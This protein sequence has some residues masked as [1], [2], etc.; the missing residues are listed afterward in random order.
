L[1][2]RAD[3]SLWRQDVEFIASLYNVQLRRDQ[4]YAVEACM[5]KQSFSGAQKAEMERLSGAG[6]VA[7]ALAS[8]DVQSVREAL[9]KKNLE[10][11]IETA[12]RK[13][14][15]IQRNVRGSEGEKDNLMPKFFALRL[16]SGCSSLF[17]H[18]QST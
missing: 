9:R 11:P 3:S 6:L 14:Q 5:R 1:L 2:T 7:N 8:G 12:F 10:K 17:F 18:T 13:M 16:W 4:V 15:I